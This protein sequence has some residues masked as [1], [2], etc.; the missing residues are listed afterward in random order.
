MPVRTRRSDRA[1]DQEG[2]VPETLWHHVADGPHGQR[3]IEF[4]EFAQK[5]ADNPQQVY[6][7][8]ELI[9]ANVHEEVNGLRTSKANYENKYRVSKE[10]ISALERE[11]VELRN[12]V[13]ALEEETSQLEEER[14]D[15]KAEWRVLGRRIKEMQSGREASMTPSIIASSV[16]DV[17]I[18]PPKSEKVADPPVFRGKEDGKEVE[19]KFEDWILAMKRKLRANADRFNT[20]ELRIAYIAGRVGGEAANHLR[21][22]LDEEHPLYAETA[23]QLFAKLQEV[24]RDP[25]RLDK[26]RASFH[27]LSMGPKDDFHTFHTRFIQ[28]AYEAKIQEDEHKYYLNEKLYP[29]LRELVIREYA[30]EGTF[31]EFVNA[32]ATTAHQLKSIS[33]S[34]ARRRFRGGARNRD[35]TPD[36]APGRKPPDDSSAKGLDARACY[37]CG[38]IGHI[39]KWCKNDARDKDAAV[40]ELEA[41]LA[42]AGKEL[43]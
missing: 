20:E 26:A 3:K 2:D 39:A 21:P 6:R 37:K 13:D 40:R 18:K 8:L 17:P 34:E 38:K 15:Y 4:E 29:R 22:Y 23:D 31:A 11:I 33:E 9:F 14:D 24:Y 42:E 16:G 10:K 25:N 43:A 5:I 19:P 32:C 1:D 7:D 12:R 27:K 28:L 35:R 41:D 30:K 36:A